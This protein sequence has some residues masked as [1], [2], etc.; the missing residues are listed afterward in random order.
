M[1]LPFGPGAGA[2]AAMPALSKHGMGAEKIVV[3]ERR[4]AQMRRWQSI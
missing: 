2:V 4:T 3:A 1:A